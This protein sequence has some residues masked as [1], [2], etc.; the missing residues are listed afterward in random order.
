MRRKSA[1]SIILGTLA[2][3]AVMLT[4]TGGASA[5][6][7][8]KT[9]Y[10]FTPGKD[11]F[12]PYAGLIFDQAGNLYGTTSH[13][14]TSN[15]GAV[16]ELTAN[17]NGGWTES[18]LYSFCSLARCADGD[19]PFASLISDQKGSLYGTTSLG[20]AKNSG[21]VFQ[22][23]PS[24]S[25]GWTESVLYSFC[26]LANCADG[27]GPPSANLIFDEAGSLYGITGVGGAK[28]SGTVFQLTPNRSGGWTESVL[29]SFCSL[30]NCADGQTPQGG[31]IFDQAGNLYG[32]TYAGGSSNTGGTVFELTPN[33]NGGWTESVLYSFGS[34]T[35]FA[36]GQGPL[37]GLALDHSRNLYG[38]TNSGGNSSSGGTVFKLTPNQNGGWTESVLHGFCS[39]ANCADG[40]SPW[41]GLTSDQ[42]GNLYGTATFGGIRGY[43]VAFK[44]TPK[45]GGGWTYQRLHA[46]LDKPGAIP[47]AGVI[48]DKTGNVYGTTTGGAGSSVGS[49]FEITP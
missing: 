25:G 21:T 4:L 13:G 42:S 6:V 29:Y 17:Q 24:R 34:L 15:A 27:E 45:S 10:K 20:G 36:D 23:T 39:M 46:F 35:N 48:L 33:Q 49:V 31:L 22:L 19:E 9:L 2:S 43:G 11:G 14:G 47:Y 18:V 40:Q 32:T 1:F 8:F 41:A 44:M 12:Y 26:S 3:L 16:F 7:K 28:N 5:Q 38:T 37:G 30:A